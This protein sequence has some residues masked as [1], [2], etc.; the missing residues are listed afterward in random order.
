VYGKHL[1]PDIATAAPGRRPEGHNFL[2]CFEQLRWPVPALSAYLSN[3]RI[4]CVPARQGFGFIG[5]KFNKPDGYGPTSVRHFVE[6]TQILGE[7]TA[8]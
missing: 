2:F 3:P 7:R 5:D 8:D 1:I 6:D 4:P